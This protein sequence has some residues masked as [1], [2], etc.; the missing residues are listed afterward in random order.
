M[1]Q[2]LVLLTSSQVAPAGASGPSPGGAP[3]CPRN[4]DSC[5]IKVM[6]FSGASIFPENVREETPTILCKQ[7]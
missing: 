1:S 5:H 2:T 4:K 7:I 6:L 3:Q